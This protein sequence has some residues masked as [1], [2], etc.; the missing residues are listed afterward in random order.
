MNDVHIERDEKQILRELDR[1][2]HGDILDLS[3][4]KVFYQRKAAFAANV[5][6]IVEESGQQ[7]YRLKGEFRKFYYRALR[8]R[9]ETDPRRS[10]DAA[11]DA[12]LELAIFYL[13]TSGRESAHCASGVDAGGIELWREF[14]SSCSEV[15]RMGRPTF[16]SHIYNIAPHGTLIPCGSDGTHDVEM[17]VIFDVAG[18]NPRVGIILEGTRVMAPLVRA[19]ICRHRKGQKGCEKREL[20]KHVVDSIVKEFGVICGVQKRSSGRPKK[21]SSEKWPAESAVAPSRPISPRLVAL[22]QN[23]PERRDWLETMR[24]WKTFRDCG[25]LAMDSFTYEMHP[26]G[27]LVPSDSFAT[28]DLVLKID[29]ALRVE[30]PR[31]EIFLEGISAIAP[32]FQSW[33]RKQYDGS[34]YRQGNAALNLLH[35]IGKE[36]RVIFGVQLRNK[37]RPMEHIGQRAA[38]LHDYEEKSWRETAEALGQLEP[39]EDKEHAVDLMK[40][41]TKNY[42]ASLRKQMPH[43]F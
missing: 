6:A 8:G 36:L 19:W 14:E 22:P 9:L 15:H 25:Q 11:A 20:I 18:P 13:E 4:A 7:R 28:D 29:F 17:R 1:L 42:Y 40:K 31:I 10:D 34:L 5:K 33:L 26:D 32:L 38:F 43:R 3:K 2:L 30:R 37:G 35:D 16:E 27:R 24:E 12:L 39:G 23:G 41:A 21:R